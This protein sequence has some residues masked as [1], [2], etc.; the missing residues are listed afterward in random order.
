[1][2]AMLEEDFLMRNCF[3]KMVMGKGC[4]VREWVCFVRYNKVIGFNLA[5]F[6]I[7]YSVPIG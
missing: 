1:M 2:Y 7:S 6:I 3:Q 4:V 5:I